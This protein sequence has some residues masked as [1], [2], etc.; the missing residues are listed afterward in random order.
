MIPIFSLILQ[1]SCVG[2]SQL[3]AERDELTAQVT[4]LQAS[5][6]RLEAEKKVLDGRLQKIQ[7]SSLSQRQSAVDERR[8]LQE[9]MDALTEDQVWK[10]LR[11]AKGQAMS[12]DFTTTLGDVT[13]ALWPEKAPM[14]VLNFVD[15]AEGS[16][17]WKDPRTN[18]W[19][20]RSLYNGT[21]FHRVIPD[22]MIQG[23]DPMGTGR[24]GPGYRFKDEKQP[25]VTFEKPGLLAMANAGPNT[26]GSQF[27]IT[28]GTPTH[29]NGKHTIFGGD[30]EPMKV[31]QAIARTKAVRN[32]PVTDVVVSR[33][34]IRRGG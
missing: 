26:N 10:R 12:V 25:G 16:R 8:K 28:E 29:L 4:E 17:E 18:E 30:C 19:V 3:E 14:T 32:K 21:T 15:L 22:F 7:A 5:V 2:N 34:R 6:E 13:C 1:L 20:Q 24:G 27:F 33:V 9:E 23:G 11:V 31:V